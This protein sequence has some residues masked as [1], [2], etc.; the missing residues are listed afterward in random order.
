MKSL[1]V[2]VIV[3]AVIALVLG[4]L[5]LLVILDPTLFGISTAC[6]ACIVPLW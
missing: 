5:G 6:P 1:R 2:V 4:G 3:L